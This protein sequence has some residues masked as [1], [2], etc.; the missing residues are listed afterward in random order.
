MWQWNEELVPKSPTQEL[1][2]V[3]PIA[4]APGSRAPAM[5]PISGATIKIKSRTV[6]IFRAN[7]GNGKSAKAMASTITF[8]L[9]ELNIAANTDSA[10]IPEA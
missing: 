6:A 8:R 7:T 10:L 4:S 5:E 3:E 2:S 1:I 9:G